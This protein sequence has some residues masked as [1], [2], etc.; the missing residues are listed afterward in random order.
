MSYFTWNWQKGRQN[1]ILE[2]W[3]NRCFF[4]L[5]TQIE[6]NRFSLLGMLSTWFLVQN[7]S[8]III[9]KNL[10]NLKRGAKG[11]APMS[12]KP[13]NFSNLPEIIKFHIC[14]TYIWYIV[15]FIYSYI[16]LFIL[17]VGPGPGPA[18]GSYCLWQLDKNIKD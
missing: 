16:F 15:V 1:L 4:T 17:R 8:E 18:L 10:V 11:E 5:W 14:F 3:E 9:F 7:V 2:V 12:L 13:Y 6:T